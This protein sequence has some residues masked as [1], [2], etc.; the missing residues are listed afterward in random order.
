MTEDQRQT[1]DARLML[2]GIWLDQPDEEYFD[3]IVV[4]VEHLLAWS[5]QSGLELRAGFQE[6]AG[7][8][9]GS[10]TGDGTDDPLRA[11]VG[12]AMI[13]LRLRCTTRGVT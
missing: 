7:R 8:W 6:S 4:G 1:F 13:E 2:V 10:V 12:D 3:K 11:H 5:K 9:S